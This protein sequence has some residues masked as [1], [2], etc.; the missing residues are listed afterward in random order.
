MS[1]LG[2]VAASA[3]GGGVIAWLVQRTLGSPDKHRDEV[4]ALRE[5]VIRVESRI[6]SE[7]DVGTMMH[8]L[9]TIQQQ[10]SEVQRALSELTRR[11]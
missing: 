8:V 9:T 7:G 11:P 2:A 5:R 10:M 4:A 1:D 6:G 3:A